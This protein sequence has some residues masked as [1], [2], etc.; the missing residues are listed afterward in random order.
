MKVHQWLFHAPQLLKTS[1]SNLM[2]FADDGAL[3]PPPA[4]ALLNLHVKGAR[5]EMFLSTSGCW[6]E[7]PSVP[8]VFRQIP[9]TY[10]SRPARKFSRVSCGQPMHGYAAKLRYLRASTIIFFNQHTRSLR[11]QGKKPS[12]VA[13]GGGNNTEGFVPAQRS[14][15]DR[16]STRITSFVNQAI[17][18]L[19]RLT[20]SSEYSYLMLGN[21]F[22]SQKDTW[23]RRLRHRSLPPLF[24]PPVHT[25]KSL[26]C[27]RRR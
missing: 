26:L 7:T 1:L 4:S 13:H 19:S 8:A 5:L 23:H 6:C 27:R 16:I 15:N 22:S 11:R 25:N 18:R 20:S 14:D 12:A 2:A 9:S 3:R 21:G 10:F 17:T 24:A